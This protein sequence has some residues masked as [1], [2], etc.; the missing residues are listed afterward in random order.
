MSEQHKWCR[1]Q[2]IFICSHTRKSSGKTN[3]AKVLSFCIC[4]CMNVSMGGRT[5]RVGKLLAKH[6]WTARTKWWHQTGSQSSEFVYDCWSELFVCLL[7]C[8]QYLLLFIWIWLIRALNEERRIPTTK[9]ENLC[10]NKVKRQSSFLFAYRSVARQYIR[11]FD[12]TSSRRNVRSIK[13]L[14]MIIILMLCWNN[15]LQA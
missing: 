13:K 3:D 7:V 11:V 10:L 9:L 8:D 2:L 5:V 12:G 1:M 6:L 4:V 14:G 15:Y